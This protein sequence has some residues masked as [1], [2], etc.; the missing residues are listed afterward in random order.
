MKCQGC[1]SASKQ[2]KY[3]MNHSFYSAD[4]A[5]HYRVIGS[6]F[7]AIIVVSLIGIGYF[8]KSDQL[9]SAPSLKAGMPVVTSDGGYAIIR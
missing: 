2:W 4:R 5:T 6:A 3:P 7:I 1:P 9:A 8:A